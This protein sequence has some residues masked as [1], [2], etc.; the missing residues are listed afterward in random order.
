MRERVLQMVPL[1][2]SDQTVVGLLAR[3]VQVGALRDRVESRRDAYGG[4]MATGGRGWLALYGTGASV[5]LPWSGQP[6]TYLYRLVPGLLCEVGLAPGLPAH[7]WSA[8]AQRLNPSPEAVGA[9]VA[10]PQF[11][12]LSAAAPVQN[13]N[14]GSVA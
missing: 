6:P 3:G 12:D 14:L 11:Y 2:S 10:G 9:L 7:L 13:A 8:M 4:L 1:A 5:R